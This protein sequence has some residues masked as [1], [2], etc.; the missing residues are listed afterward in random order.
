MKKLSREWTRT[1]AKLNV[2]MKE[3]PFMDKDR[4]KKWRA[5]IEKEIAELE[6][7]QSTPDVVCLDGDEG[8]ALHKMELDLA[9]QKNDGA[10]AKNLIEER[11]Q[12][13]EEAMAEAAEDE[14]E[15]E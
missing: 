3:K 10:D 14:A 6:D 4:F 2:M 12:W 5:M 9:I 8:L 1:F 7:L 11:L 15:E 13:E